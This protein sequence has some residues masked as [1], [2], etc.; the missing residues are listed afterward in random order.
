M[1]SSCGPRRTAL[2]GQYAACSVSHLLIGVFV[3]ALA[4][5]SLFS[6]QQQLNC[7]MSSKLQNKLYTILFLSTQWLPYLCKINKMVFTQL[8]GKPASCSFCDLPTHYS[9]YTHFQ[10][11]MLHSL[12]LFEC[13][14]CYRL[15]AVVPY[16]SLC[17]TLLTQIST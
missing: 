9:S 7:F 16:S 6:T 8:L 2:F 4:F 15:C 12:L 13:Q 17:W 5:S 3:P 14:V 11:T 10:L 1:E